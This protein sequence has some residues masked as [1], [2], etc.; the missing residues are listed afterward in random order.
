MTRTKTE[1]IKNGAFGKSVG[2]NFEV[3]NIIGVPHPF[4]V[5]SKHVSYAA[6]HCG[7]MLGEEVMEKI[8]CCHCKKKYSEHGIA[9]V[10]SCHR[11]TAKNAELQ[12]YLISIKDRAEAE[13]FVGFVFVKSDK[14]K[15]ILGGRGMSRIPK[16]YYPYPAKYAISSDLEAIEHSLKKWEGIKANKMPKDNLSMTC[17]LCWRTSH[18]NSIANGDGGRM[19]HENAPCVRVSACRMCAWTKIRDIECLHDDVGRMGDA[20]GYSPRIMVRILKEMREYL[21]S[22]GVKNF[23]DINRYGGEK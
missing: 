9:L 20:F 4:V 6:D 3:T 22:R 21:V 19:F 10:V 8:P 7:G 12:G 5:G 11:P 18:M 14:F 15:D 1:E 13:G 17:A 16:K 2:G 23:D